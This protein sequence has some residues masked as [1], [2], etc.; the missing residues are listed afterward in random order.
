MSIYNE[1]RQKKA[2]IP[3]AFIA[4]YTINI[5]ASVL[6]VVSHNTNIHLKLYKLV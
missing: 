1:Y 5:S 4:L 6:K 2:F 3:K